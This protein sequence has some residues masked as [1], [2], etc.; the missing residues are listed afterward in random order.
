MSTQRRENR[1]QRISC[2][3]YERLSRLGSL[4]LIAWFCRALATVG[5]APPLIWAWLATNS[6][7]SD[8]HMVSLVGLVVHDF[9]RSF[10]CLPS[11]RVGRSDRSGTPATHTVSPPFTPTPSG[12]AYL[13][14]TLPRVPAGLSRW[15]ERYDGKRDLHLQH[16][17]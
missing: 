7:Q 2:T 4:G 3:E 11:Q 10:R 14:L 17:A 16:A 15:T 6:L 5:T 8:H 12:F 9:R 13:H 1:W